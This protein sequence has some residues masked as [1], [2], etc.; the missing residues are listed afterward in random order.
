VVTLL[1][2]ESVTNEIPSTNAIGI[3]EVASTATNTITAVPWKR[4]ASAP[5]EAPDL[6]VS[7]FVAYANLSAG[8]KVYMLDG[9][10][11]KMWTKDSNGT[12]GTATTVSGAGVS[13][14][15][16]PHV[17]TIPCGGAVW[18]QRTDATKPYFLVGQYD[19]SA[20]SV[21]VPGSGAAL[22]ANPFT[23]NVMLNAINWDASGTNDT[24]RIR[25]PENGLYVGLS[26]DSTEQKWGYYTPKT[27]GTSITG[28][29]FNSYNA[30]IPPGTGF[31]YDRRGGEG[32]T[33]EWK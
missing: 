27:N 25:N 8:D 28:M 13:E 20:F 11:Y 33:F 32:F 14:P 3:V 19:E 7:N 29:E 15:A 12:W 10:D 23:T 1:A 18:V 26:Y 31:I 9:R 2:Y 16:A 17:A 6:T 5:G 24:I 30:T 22:I 4:L 21:T